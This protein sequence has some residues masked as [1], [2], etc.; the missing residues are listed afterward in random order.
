MQNQQSYMQLSHS[1]YVKHGGAHNSPA[2]SKMILNQS[3]CFQRT[4][5]IKL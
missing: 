2:R 5:E 4:S 1:I 3:T